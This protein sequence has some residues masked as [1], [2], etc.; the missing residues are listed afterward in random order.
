MVV[1]M[2]AWPKSCCRLQLAG[3]T[4]QLGK[5]PP[6]APR[7]LLLPFVLVLAGQAVVTAAAGW[8]ATFEVAEPGFTIVEPLASHI[9]SERHHACFIVSHMHQGT[10]L[11]AIAGG[12]LLCLWITWRRAV[13]ALGESGAKTA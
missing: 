9:P 4:A 3:F 6:L 2:G 10:Y 7:A 1:M 13:L 11:G 5:R 12:V 8:Q